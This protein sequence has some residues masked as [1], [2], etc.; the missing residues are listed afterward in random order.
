M[1]L[2]GPTVECLFLRPDAYGWA[3][4]LLSIGGLPIHLD[5][6]SKIHVCAQRALD[7][8][9]VWNMPVRG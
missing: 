1:P 5:Q 9:Q 8:F 4:P 6:L 7:S 3:V 2:V